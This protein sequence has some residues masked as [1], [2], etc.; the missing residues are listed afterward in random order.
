MRR[1][2]WMADE[3]TGAAVG[4]YKDGDDGTLGVAVAVGRERTLLT[5]AEARTMAA[6]LVRSADQADAGLID[7]QN[8]VGPDDPIRVAPTQ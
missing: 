5:S 2:R 7:A 6:A 4:V 3:E 8:V 1:R